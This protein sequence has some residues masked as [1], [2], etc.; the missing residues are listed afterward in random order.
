MWKLALC[1][2]NCT[3]PFLLVRS[4]AYEGCTWYTAQCH[5][6]RT[7]LDHNWYRGVVAMALTDEERTELEA[8]ARITLERNKRKVQTTIAWK[9]RQTPEK[10]AAIAKRANELRRKKGHYNIQKYTRKYTRRQQIIDYLGGRCV[11][12]LR[13]F[14]PNVYDVHHLGEKTIKISDIYHHKWETIIEEIND[15]VL[16]CANCHR[17]RHVERTNRRLSVYR[18][19][20]AQRVLALERSIWGPRSRP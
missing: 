6:G 2:P 20:D 1:K 9:A 16:L 19:E 10:L 3:G 18:H 15:C 12:C 14:H 13:V 8:D 17:M 4:R 11:D 5:I 7:W